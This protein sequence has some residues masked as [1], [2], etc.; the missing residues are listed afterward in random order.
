VTQR[1]LALHAGISQSQLAEIE[2]GT[3]T[4]GVETLKKLAR[5]LKISLDAL[6]G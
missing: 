5:A 6:T 3:K 4:G 2:T 1:Q